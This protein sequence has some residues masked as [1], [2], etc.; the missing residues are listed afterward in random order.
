MG[1]ESN[2]KCPHVAGSDLHDPR[3]SVPLLPVPGC[4]RE[5]VPDVVTQL[6][7]RVRACMDL[8]VRKGRKQKESEVQNGTVQFLR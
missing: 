2:L 3:F 5:L 7:K 6:G 4:R 8:S 1:L